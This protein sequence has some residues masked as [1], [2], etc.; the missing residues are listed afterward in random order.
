MAG[1]S[2]ETI[3]SGKRLAEI[4]TGLFLDFINGLVDEKAM[5]LLQ[6]RQTIGKEEEW[7]AKAANKIDKKGAILVLAWSNGKLAGLSEAKLGDG[8]F[9]SNLDFGLS[10]AKD[11]RRMGIGRKL[12]QTALDDGRRAFRPHNIHIAYVGG[13]EP[14]RKLYESMGFRELYR[15]REYYSYYGE[16]RDNVI[17]ELR[18]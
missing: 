4:P 8:P 2:F 13:N 17:M 12:L 5:I 16:F 1:I 3:T 11:F 10:V 6:E 14:A 18:R 7:K 15:L 9:A